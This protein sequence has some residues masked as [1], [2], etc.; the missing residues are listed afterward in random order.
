[1]DR[2]DIVKFL[3]VSGLSEVEEIEYKD[4]ETLVLRFFYDFDEDELSAAQAYAKEE[5]KEDENEE[6]FYDYYVPYL[7][8]I[9]VDNVSDIVEGLMEEEGVKAQF[10]SYE[11]EI[12][13]TDEEEPY[14]EFIAVI[15]EDKDVDIEKVLEE[16][17]L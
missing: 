16:L 7:N 2:D 5:C 10:I 12:D 6:K 1:M 14:T 13:E 15:T 4:K 8:E 3:L 17:N 9:S 11:V